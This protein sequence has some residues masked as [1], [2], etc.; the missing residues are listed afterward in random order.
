MSKNWTYPWLL[1]FLK[2]LP[3][4]F[5]SESSARIKGKRTTGPAVQN[6]ISSTK[7]REL[8]AKNQTV[9]QSQSLVYLLVPLQR[10][11]QLHHHLRHRI[12]NLTST[13]TPKI[14][15]QKEVEARVR[16]YGETRCMKPQKPKTKMKDTKKYKRSNT[17]I[18]AGIVREFGRW[19]SS[20]WTEIAISAWEPKNMQGFLQKTCCVVDVLVR[21]C[22]EREILVIS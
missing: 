6:H 4:F 11:H 17:W 19:K 16:S 15:H 1:C 3:Q 7:A 2:E 20:R 21:S 14:Q 22:A 12:P 8:I 10:P 18:A 13:G 5:L 9:C